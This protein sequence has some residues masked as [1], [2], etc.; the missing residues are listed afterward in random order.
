[1]RTRFAR[2]H[3]GLAMAL[4]L[5][6]IL[7]GSA[8]AGPPLICHAF[9][10]GSAKS[11]PWISHS[12]N[13]TGG[14]TYDTSKLVSDTF[15][16]LAANP[17]VLVRME[18][19]RRATLYARKDPAVAK[20]LLTKLTMGTKTAP[21]ADAAALHYFDVG[22]LAQTYKQWL[23]EG[24][25]NPASALDGYALVK[26]AIQLRPNDAQMEFAAAL[27]TLSGPVSEHQDHVQ[28]ATAGAKNDPL[29]ARN[30]ASH[31]MGDRGET[32]AEALT[33][34]TVLTELKR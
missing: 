17:P 9:D 34:P 13:L 24:T 15:A 21:S 31:F 1:M 30:L 3:R 2:T 28:K 6:L 8:I 14:E 25:Q 18:T 26:Q 22:Y 33:K 7:A 4:S 5:M 12:W 29:L 16:I 27:I 23:G 32:V 20:E 19:L 10:I 11:L